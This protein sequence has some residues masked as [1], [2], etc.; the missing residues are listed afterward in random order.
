MAPTARGIMI[1]RAGTPDR[2]DAIWAEAADGGWELT[3]HV[4]CVADAV[5]PGD[6]ADRRA[7]RQ[8]QTVYLRDSAIAMLPR[9]TGA[10]ATLSAAHERPALAVTWHL[11][12]DG[13][14]SGER[15]RRGTL[16]RPAELDYESAT[17]AI[18][19]RAHP[20][21]QA[22]AA[23]HDAAQVLLARRRADGALALYDLARGWA[24]DGD[25]A[26]RQLA[27]VER[28]AAYIVVAELMVEANRL[29]AGFCVNGDIPALFRNHQAAAAA[30]PRE[31]LMA[32]LGLAAGGDGE[33]WQRETA[34]Q[35]LAHLLR[36]AVYAPHA[37]GH[38]GLRLPWYCHATSPLRRYPDLVTQR[39]V[40]AA[41]RGERPPHSAGELEEIAAAVNAAIQ[42]RRDSRTE[43]LKEK[44]KRRRR[45]ELAGGGYRDV[46]S[47]QFHRLVKLA[48]KEQ[49]H[50]PELEGELLRRA[51]ADELQAR[52]AYPV[53]T[54]AGPE[55]EA[56]RAAL[57]GW[58]ARHPEHAVT[59]ASIHA[60]NLGMETPLWDE[61]H[62]GTVNEPLFS[63]R[64]GI[65]ADGRVTWSATRTAR[66]KDTARQL[67]ALSLIAGLAG[68]PD[69]SPASPALVQAPAPD[70]PSADDD[71]RSPVT[72]LNELGQTGVLLDIGYKYEQNGPPH[73]PEFTCTAT[74]RHAPSGEPLAADAAAKNKKTAKTAAARRLYE[75]VAAASRAAARP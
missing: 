31:E 19:D 33:D 26:L 50:T 67:A 53:L 46:P 9:A 28:H 16:P 74:A 38:F 14:V 66:R 51:A 71:A 73:D 10:A 4:A 11:D 23:A 64:A 29:I 30:P 13:R 59:L 47:E 44:D 69:P 54:A 37:A 7:A 36:P 58:L 2:D 3:V 25:G 40:L 18:I 12:A 22:L 43:W 17:A 49:L 35:R 27:A 56:G 20:Q 65:D 61:S 57:A 62:V 32:D 52:D 60:R 68:Q 1:D 48:V 55:W 39:Q 15:I 72:V 75:R 5:R 41:L 8:A 21:H 24:S 6:A 70:G 42:E 63:A 34:R 45:A